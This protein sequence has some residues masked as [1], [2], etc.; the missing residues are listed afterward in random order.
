MNKIARIL[1]VVTTLLTLAMSTQAQTPYSMYGYGIMGERATSAQRQMGSVGIAQS[2]GRFVNI[3]NPAAYAVTDS[4]TFLFDMGAD[5]TFLWS[6]EGSAKEK[7]IGGGVDYLAMQ[8]PMGKY[9]GGSIGLVPLSSVGYAFGNEI[10]HG[11]V[12]NQGNGGINE[13]YLGI[14]GGYKGFSLGFNASYMFGHIANDVFSTPTGHGQTKFE[15]VMSIR[16]WNILIGA[17]YTFKF[18]RFNKMTF[19]L[20][21]SPKKT[22]L[23]RTRVTSQALSQD[24]KM[25]TIANYSMRKRYYMPNC[26]GA[27]VSYTYEKAYRITGEFDFSWQGWKDC[28]YSE[29]VAN[30]K[31]VDPVSGIYKDGEV[32]FEGMKFDNR[33]RYAAGLEYIP[34]LRGNYGERMTYRLGGYYC[35]DYLN[36]KGNQVKEYGVSCGFGFPTPEGKTLINLGFEWRHRQASPATLISENYLNITLGINFNEVWFFK[37]KIR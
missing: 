13:L 25:D 27:G 33:L 36:I 5:I 35:N 37:R 8:F 23:G 10:A 29:L 34:R 22:L 17:Q 24:A 9:F 16:D 12:E 15:H 7:A 4:M 26:W 19:G 11:A 1:L 31:V 6:Q 28:K 18:N 20:T 21:Y 30:Q 32:V 3:M 14:G 2:N